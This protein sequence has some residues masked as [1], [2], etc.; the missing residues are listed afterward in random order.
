MYFLWMSFHY[1]LSFAALQALL[2]PSGNGHIHMLWVCM[3][4]AAFLDQMPSHWQVCF[5]SSQ[6]WS[7]LRMRITSWSHCT[8]I[9]H[10]WRTSQHHQTTI[11]TSYTRDPHQHRQ[12]QAET[13]GQLSQRQSAEDIWPSHIWGEPHRRIQRSTSVHCTVMMAHG[14]DSTSVEDGRNVC[15]DILSPTAPSESLTLSCVPLHG[16]GLSKTLIRREGGHSLNNVFIC[17]EV[18]AAQGSVWIC[19]H[20]IITP[21]LCLVRDK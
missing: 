11:P 4:S 5:L 14:R 8:H 15:K 20:Y 13:G 2:F 21:V 9:R 6:V 10:F 17:K 3:E 16:A 18:T 1:S 19:F 7:E 12:T